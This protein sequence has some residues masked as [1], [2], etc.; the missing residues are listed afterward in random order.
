LVEE[1][2]EGVIDDVVHLETR[3]VPF[4]ELGTLRNEELPRKRVV[5][6]PALVIRRIAHKETLLHVRLQLLPLVLLDEDVRRAAKHPEAAEIRLL[7]VPGFVGRLARK[8]RGRQAVPDLDLGGEAAT[9]EGGR[10]LGLVK[11]RSDVLQHDPVGS[12]CI[13]VL[14]GTIPSGVEPEDA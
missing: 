9:P 11:H 6:V 5:E 3:E 12:L 2:Q 14:L 10:Q 8:R 7:T 4:V 13:S 1:T